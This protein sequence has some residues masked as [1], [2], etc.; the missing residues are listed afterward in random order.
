MFIVWRSKN[1]IL[2]VLAAAALLTAIVYVFTP[3]TAAGQEGSP[4]GFFTNTR[5]LIPGL[6]LAMVMLPLA[7]PLR[8]PD[9]R[10][11]ITLIF[12]GVVYWVTVLTTPQWYTTY[13]FGAIFLTLALVWVPAALGLG[14]SRGVLSRRIVMIAGAV[15]LLAAVVLG[16][17]QQVQYADQHYTNTGLF[18]QDGGPEKAY[19]YAQKLQHQRIGIVGDSEI[20]FGQYGFFGNPPTNEVEYIGV[21][22]PHGSYRL[23]TSCPQFI[24]RVNAGN[25]DYLIM[26]R[27]TEDSRESPEYGRILLPRLR[28]GERRP[29]AGTESRRADD[30]AAA[31]LRLQGEWSALGAVLPDQS[32]RKNSSQKKKRRK[33]SRWKRKRNRKKK[34]RRTPK[35]R[36][37][38]AEE[39][40]VE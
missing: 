10:A 23:A 28:V 33:K 25:Y 37:K 15:V 22:G 30:P 27:A 32:G 18:L 34:K 9:R 6:V 29:G 11:Q 35:R 40:E 13:I 2:R 4:T 17:A 3:L 31:G 24:E 8:A 7:R 19:A 26:S 36:K 1:K 12:L 39:A 21:P 38:K 5:Y 14:R 20:I 16:R